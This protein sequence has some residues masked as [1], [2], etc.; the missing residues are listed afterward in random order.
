MMTKVGW[1]FIVLAVSHFPAGAD[2]QAISTLTVLHNFGIS[3]EPPENLAAPV[4][5][6]P[7]GTLYGTTAQG[8]INNDGTVFKIQTNGTGLTVLKEF[9]NSPD[10]QNP[11]S[12]L[13]LSGGTLYGTTRGGGSYG[14]GTVFAVNTDGTGFTNLCSFQGW[15]DG[16]NPQAGLVL[17][18]STLYGVAQNGGNGGS[19]AVFAINTDGTG[20]TNLYSFSPKEYWSL[21]NYTNSDGA[22]PMGALVL[23]G[24]NLYGTT[25]QGGTNTGA[26]TM[27]AIGTNGTGFSDCQLANQ[28]P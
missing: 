12:G 28:I 2:A 25:S 21:N 16:A 17:S 20:F 26:G 23:S 1:L 7:D 15:S 14:L 8:G 19:G 27:F 24:G 11:R 5:Q 3:N 9:T 18:G 22:N 6:G 4:M 13:V 10:G